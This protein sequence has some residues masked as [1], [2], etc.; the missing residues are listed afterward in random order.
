MFFAR[1]LHHRHHAIHATG[2]ACYII[3]GDSGV[4]E[5]KPHK[6]APPLNLWPV[7]ELVTH[8]ITLNEN[9]G[10]AAWRAPGNQFKG[11]FLAV[12]DETNRLS[13]TDDA[14]P[15]RRFRLVKTLVGN[16]NSV[17]QSVPSR[18]QLAMPLL[19]V[20]PLV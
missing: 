8:G 13:G 6:F 14:I 1:T 7:K 2:L 4:L 17:S 9:A 10:H 3:V 20:T 11:M 5:R 16:S 19:I 12:L 18:A 15:T